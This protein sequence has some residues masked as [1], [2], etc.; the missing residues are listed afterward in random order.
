M[1]RVA[2]EVPAKLRYASAAGAADRGRGKR[3]S[4]RSTTDLSPSIFT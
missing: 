4:K 2:K 3:V 1:E